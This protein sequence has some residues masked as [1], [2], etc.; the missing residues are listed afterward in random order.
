MLSAAAAGVAAIVAPAYAQDARSTDTIIAEIESAI[1]PSMTARRG[2]D[3]YTEALAQYGKDRA[4]H[5]ETRAALILELYKADRTHEDVPEYMKQRWRLLARQS[6]T[7]DT[8]LKETNEVAETGE[9]QFAI[10]ASFTYARTIGMKTRYS[11]DEFEPALTRFIKMALDERPAGLLMTAARSM[12]DSERQMATYRRALKDYPD[13]RAT[14]YTAGKIKQIE[15]MNKPF[16]LEFSD[17]ISGDTISMTSLRGKV[18]VIDFWATWCGPCIREIPHM[19]E[20]YAAYA[21][22]GVEFIG[23]SLDKPVE[24]GGL[25]KLKKYVDEN[26]IAW[27][28]FYQGNGWASEFSASWGI[29]SI[30][31]LFAVDREGNLHTVQAHGKIEEL[32]HELLAD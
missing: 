16:K 22:K 3:G 14:R 19:K 11:E 10:D 7:T 30:P 1:A 24:D 28:Q 8:I 4:T 9:G 2:D 21:D 18:V 32:I 15:G 12:E 13:A 20:L 27:P 31:T 26:E 5:N 29:N 25:E 23:I 6:G 17:A